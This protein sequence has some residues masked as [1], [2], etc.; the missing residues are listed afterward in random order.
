MESDCA[1]EGG[2]D[3]GGGDVMLPVATTIKIEGKRGCEISVV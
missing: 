3:V 2:R 1:F